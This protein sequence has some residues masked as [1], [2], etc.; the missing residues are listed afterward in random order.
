MARSDLL[1]AL[2]KAG[3]SGEPKSGQSSTTFLPIACLRRPK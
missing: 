3:S 1:V 2:V